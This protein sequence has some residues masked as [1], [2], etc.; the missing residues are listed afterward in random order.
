M[1]VT[2]SAALFALGLYGVL[3]R[4]DLVAILA[5]IEVMLTGVT[6]FVIGVGAARAALLSQ[7]VVLVF[8]TLA[9]AEAVVGIALVLAT[10]RRTGLDRAEELDEVRG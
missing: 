10:V 8:L 4:R 6:T 7:V 5:A 9:A 2:V 1:I 3:T